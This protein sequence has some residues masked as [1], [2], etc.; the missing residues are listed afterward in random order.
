MADIRIRPVTPADFHA[1][2]PLWDGYNAFYGRSGPT[3]LPPAI[4]QATWGRFHDAAEPVHALVAEDDG[5]LLGLAHFLFHRSTTAIADTCYL[6]DLFT[7]E[8]ARGRGIGSALIT[9]V[10]DRARIAGS[11]RVYWQTHESNAVARRL[12][13][14]VG[15]DSGF[16]VYRKLVD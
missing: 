15:E 5:Q 7:I 3:A 2:L 11:G 1:W 16:I 4:T 10:H 14:Q 6:Q 8:A 13:D 12:Y 9:A